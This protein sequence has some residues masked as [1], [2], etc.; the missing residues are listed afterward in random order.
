MIQSIEQ[1][2]ANCRRWADLLE[3]YAGNAGHQYLHTRDAD[4]VPHYCAWGLA[5]E[6]LAQNRELAP[7]A[8]W[9]PDTVLANGTTIYRPS[10]SDDATLPS[11]ALFPAFGFSEQQLAAHCPEFNCHPD[12]AIPLDALAEQ[13]ADGL[14]DAYLA[15]GED[16]VTIA[17]LS[18]AAGAAG[19]P[20]IAR[21]LE[22]HAESLAP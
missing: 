14:P 6:A 8:V 22:R 1:Q 18:D 19:W 3:R 10:D 16:S 7:D 12:V 5:I 20:S 2:Q 15:D 13:V 9:M 21:F 11:P 4:G 17:N